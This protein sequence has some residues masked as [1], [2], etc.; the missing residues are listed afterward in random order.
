MDCKLIYLIVLMVLSGALAIVSL[1]QII[2]VGQFNMAIFTALTQGVC[3]SWISQHPLTFISL[4]ITLF[5]ASLQLSMFVLTTVANWK[6]L[7]Y[8]KSLIYFLPIYSLAEIV[9]ACM[10]LAAESSYTT[11][12]MA[13]YLTPQ[14]K[15]CYDVA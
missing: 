15:M 10:F 2:F 13:F 3:Q 7:H 8:C 1:V 9:A 12:M 14:C 5:M 4:K 11:P 6:E